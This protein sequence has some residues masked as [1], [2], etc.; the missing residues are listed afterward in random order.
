MRR[1][2]SARDQHSDQDIEEESVEDSSTGQIDS[3]DAEPASEIREVVE[4][5]AGSVVVDEESVEAGAKN[6]R[7]DEHDSEEPEMKKARTDEQDS[8]MQQQGGAASSPEP[9]S[10]TSA[11][12]SETVAEQYPPVAQRIE[13]YERDHKTRHYFTDLTCEEMTD[14]LIRVAMFE[15]DQWWRNQEGH[16]ATFRVPRKTTEINIKRLPS[17]EQRFFAKADQAEWANIVRLGAVRVH[18]GAEALS[19]RKQWPDRIMGSRLV[20][21]VRTRTAGS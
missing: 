18:R 3:V 17:E 16:Y 5:A 14:D 9:V 19:R 6:A 13:D 4:S 15:D 21:V 1:S 2:Q 10:R 7:S 11:G 8:E 12:S 20:A